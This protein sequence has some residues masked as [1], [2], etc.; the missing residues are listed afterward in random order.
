MARA[1]SPPAPPLP[2]RPP[3]PR[4]RSISRISSTQVQPNPKVGRSVEDNDN[5]FPLDDEKNA[6]STQKK[7]PKPAPVAAA[8]KEEKEVK[9]ENKEIP[10]GKKEQGT[11]ATGASDEDEKDAKMV[12]GPSPKVIENDTAKGTAAI[13]RESSHTKIRKSLVGV[14][15]TVDISDK[16]IQADVLKEEKYWEE[17]RVAFQHLVD[18]VYAGQRTLTDFSSLVRKQQKAAQRAAAYLTLDGAWEKLGRTEGLGMREICLA[19]HKL[20]LGLENHFAT[21]QSD[22]YEKPIEEAQKAAKEFYEFNARIQKQASAVT[23]SIKRQANLA[24]KKWGYYK[25]AVDKR[26]KTHT[27]TEK[28]IKTSEDPYLYFQQYKKEIIILHKLQAKYNNSMA[29]IMAEFETRELQRARILRKLVLGLVSA[30]KALVEKA[31]VELAATVAKLSSIDLEA[32]LLRFRHAGGL[33]QAPA[34]EVEFRPVP[35]GMEFKG[36]EVVNVVKN[37]QASKLGIQK[38]WRVL[39]IDG[40]AAPSGHSAIQKVIAS[41]KSKGKPIKLRFGKTNVEMIF[42]KPPPKRK[43]QHI[44]ILSNSELATVGNL[45]RMSKTMGFTSWTKMH[46][47]ITCSGI[48]HVMNSV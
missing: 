33:I 1:K 30:Q 36:N 16:A 9:S 23:A 42:T 41:L 35:F 20:M 40:K 28:A 32:D 8:K 45:S 22:M 18:R 3:P 6:I 34:T 47:V 7:S 13:P 10:T 2:N 19:Q 38:G 44:N 37:S 25:W 29:K 26:H 48:L 43:T 21:V 39:T 14:V 24:M 5:P 27:T 15:K 4:S 12:K 11:A 17:Q 46:C 31:Q